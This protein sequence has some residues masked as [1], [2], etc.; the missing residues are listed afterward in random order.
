MLCQNLL[1]TSKLCYF[2]DCHSSS[3]GFTVHLLP[4]V[5][6]TFC[7]SEGN[8]LTSFVLIRKKLGSVF[9]E[10]VGTCVNHY[11]PLFKRNLLLDNLCME[12]VA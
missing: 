11:V 9:F 12:W 7:K 8:C 5:S 10:S 4:Y 3:I 6:N 1:L 2:I